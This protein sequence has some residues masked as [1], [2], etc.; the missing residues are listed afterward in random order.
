MGLAVWLITIS[1]VYSI[2]D[3]PPPLEDMTEVINRI[4]AL[5]AKVDKQQR[6]SEATGETR[7]IS[8][9]A[10]NT[11]GASRISNDAQQQSTRPRQ[12][13]PDNNTTPALLPAAAHPP[14]SLPAAAHPQ[15]GACGFGGM[16]KGFLAGGLESK[17]QSNSVVTK[18]ADS[19][20]PS[21]DGDMPHIKSNP[22]VGGDQLVMQEVQRM[23]E[24]LQKTGELRLESIHCGTNFTLNSV[25]HFLDTHTS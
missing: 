4:S 21:D 22:S 23:R 10:T 17:K 8:D 3:L 14:A 11:C 24:Q 2:L 19:T 20:I 1:L 9:P 13:L 15:S 25:R 7:T 16:K 18:F 5:K 12:S 6:G